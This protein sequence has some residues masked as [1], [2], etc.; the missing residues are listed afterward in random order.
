MPKEAQGPDLGCG[1]WA[2]GPSDCVSREVLPCIY[3]SLD[4]FEAATA[5][6]ISLVNYLFHFTSGDEIPDNVGSLER[7][8]P[9]NVLHR[10]PDTP[11]GF[12]GCIIDLKLRA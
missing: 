8:N 6:L 9:L 12:R 7:G 5:N 4:S 1:M 3:Q 2:I 11:G 10:V